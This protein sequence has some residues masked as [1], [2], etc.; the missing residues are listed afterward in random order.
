MAA[1]GL[2]LGNSFVVTPAMQNGERDTLKRAIEDAICTMIRA[3]HR[4]LS[5]DDSGPEFG[6]LSLHILPAF[7]SDLTDD[8]RYVE[9][10]IAWEQVEGNCKLRYNFLVRPIGESLII[11]DG[12]IVAT[13]SLF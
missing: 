9:V 10:V 6:P 3:S 1:T 8:N 4:P 11:A 5:P 2:E 7:L 12:S 13:Y